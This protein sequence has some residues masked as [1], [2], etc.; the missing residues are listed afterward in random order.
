MNMQGY[1]TERYRGALHH[2]EGRTNEEIVKD[3]FLSNYPF[4]AMK[5]VSI[6]GEDPRSG[7]MG[8]IFDYTIPEFVG[9][10]KMS[11]VRPM[12]RPLYIP[13]PNRTERTYPFSLGGKKTVAQRLSFIVPQE[14]IMRANADS[15]NIQNKYF[16]YTAYWNESDAGLLFK[17]QYRLKKGLVSTS[18]IKEISE[19]IR[20][21]R[22]FET[23]KI[24]IERR[25]GN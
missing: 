8:I 23:L 14:Y 7:S 13:L 17:R 18:D 9:S 16:E 20:A 1:F 25:G 6:E 2:R 12:L 3:A 19:D 15:L 22:K 4:A 11:F 24:V 10:Q 5:R 21:L